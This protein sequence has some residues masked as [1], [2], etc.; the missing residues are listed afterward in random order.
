LTSRSGHGEGINADV[1]WWRIAGLQQKQGG[2]GG[3]GICPQFAH[4]PFGR[5]LA[6]KSSGEHEQN[7]QRD[8]DADDTIHDEKAA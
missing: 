7:G 2:F 1:R 8:G 5:L 6:Q 3:A 4:V